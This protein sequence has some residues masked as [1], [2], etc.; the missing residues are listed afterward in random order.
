MPKGNIDLPNASGMIDPRLRQFHPKEPSK[1][2][3]KTV[4]EAVWGLR[5]MTP[6]VPKPPKPGSR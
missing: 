2:T 5:K 6:K 4:V 1:T 3:H